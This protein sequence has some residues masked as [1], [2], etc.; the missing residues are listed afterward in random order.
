MAKAKRSVL[1]SKAAPKALE[2]LWVNEPFQEKYP[3]LYEFLAA[4]VYEGEARKGGSVTL[5]VSSGRLKACFTDK[6]TQLAFYALLEPFEDILA[7]LE[8]AIAGEHEQWQPTSRN[9]VKVL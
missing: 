3:S 6:H 4:G 8:L 1:P 7:E 9:G 2:W 5:F